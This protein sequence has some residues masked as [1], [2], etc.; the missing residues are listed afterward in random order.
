MSSTVTLVSRHNFSAYSVKMSSLWIISLLHLHS[1]HNL[2][3]PTKS[4]PCYIYETQ[5]DFYSILFC[6]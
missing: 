4:T 3:L 1:V 2:L 6:L 5:C